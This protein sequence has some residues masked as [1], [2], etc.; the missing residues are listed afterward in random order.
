M[1]ADRPSI[2]MVEYKNDGWG[3]TTFN[4]NL[5]WY[6]YIKSFF[7]CFCMG[8]TFGHW[9]RVGPI[10]HETIV[11]WKWGGRVIGTEQRV[12]NN[13]F[14]GGR[15]RGKGL[16][17]QLLS[18]KICLF[19]LLLPFISRMLAPI[20]SSSSS[21][22]ASSSH[23]TKTF[24]TSSPKFRRKILLQGS[25]PSFDLHITLEETNV[26]GMSTISC[27]N[28]LKQGKEGAT[29]FNLVRLR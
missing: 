3:L 13:K 6:Y 16:A 2:G 14:V 18:D 21:S 8:V 27:T 23:L 22:S 12:D 4:F 10:E 19:H 7:M 15:G 20:P 17:Y 11:S 24:I 26:L 29:F 25:R 9:G 1:K 5:R 28:H